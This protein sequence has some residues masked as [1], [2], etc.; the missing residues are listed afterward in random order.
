MT[1]N[2]LLTGLASNLT[3]IAAIVA[4]VLAIGAA[5]TARKPRREVTSI[6]RHVEQLEQRWNGRLDELLDTTRHAAYLEG[7]AD[8][9]RQ[10]LQPVPAAPQEDH[11]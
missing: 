9:L 8:G 3:Q 7:M 5:V 10:H 2:D 1:L 6:H 11:A 4:A